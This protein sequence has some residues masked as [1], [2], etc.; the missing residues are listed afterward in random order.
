VSDTL[1]DQTST[2][3]TKGVHALFAMQRPD[4][5]FD[6]SVA[7][8]TSV[9]ATVG[10]VSALHAADPERS[11]DLI[12]AGAEWLCRNQY[13]DGSWSTIP[14]MPAEAGPTAVAAATLHMV[15]PQRAGE[16][17][18]AGLAWVERSGGLDAIT[19]HEMAAVCRRF[20]AQAGWLDPGE[21]KPLPLWLAAFPGLF[22]RLLDFRAPLVAAAALAQ[23]RTRQQGPAR[24]L[25]NRLGAPAA[26]RLL[27][28]IYEHE[29][30][31]GEFSEDP[32]PAGLTCGSLARADVVPDLVAL[33]V[34]WLRSQANPDGSWNMLPLELT[35]SVYAASGLIDAGHADEPRLARTRAVFRDRQQDRPFLAFGCPAGFWGWSS[36]HGWPASVE[37]AEIV[38]VLAR[39]P[40]GLEDDHVSRGVA[41]LLAQQDSR[42]SWSLC[43]RNTKVA[44]CGPCPH[45]TAQALEALLNAGLPADSPGPRAAVRWLLSSQQADGSFDSVWYRPHTSGTSV[46]LEALVKAGVGDHPV[47]VRAREW[48][49]RAQRPDG[50]WSTGDGGMPGTAEETA[51]AVSALLAAGSRGDDQAVQKGVDW[52]LQAQGPEGQWPSSPVSEFIRGASRFPNGGLTGGLAV[53]AL[54]RFREASGH[55]R[56]TMSETGAES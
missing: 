33:T 39:M 26:L 8:W 45:T 5:V 2:A 16:A 28:Q 38:S 17:V 4:G 56:E 25:L 15:A 27:R 34:D 32:W 12:E 10:A 7:G 14:G 13:P 55:G 46:V 35:W 9:L 53:R 42:G 20:Y 47:A 30:M 19:H 22:R 24:R 29:G 23:I 21:L 37:T 44:N 43:V 1:V 41:W 40:G 48:L 18:S 11:A 6:Y 31:T 54:A 3:L 50:S 36:P 51:W 52:L 49:V